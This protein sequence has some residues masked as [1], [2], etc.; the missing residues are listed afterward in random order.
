MRSPHAVGCTV[1]ILTCSVL[2]AS[3]EAHSSTPNAGTVTN[4]SGA[5]TWTGGPFVAPNPTGNAGAVNCTVPRSC[6]DYALTVSTTAGTGD[7]QNLKITVSWTNTAADF[8]AYVLDRAGAVVAS[9]A[10]SSDPETIIMPPT[11]GTYTVRVVPF[12]PL[13]QSYSASAAVVAKPSDTPPTSAAPTPAFTNYGA[14]EALTDSHNA[15]EP[16]IGVSDQ[17]NSS[18]YQSYVSTYRVR[19]DDSVSPATAAWSDVSAK[20]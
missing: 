20:A 4:T 6:D 3:G 18:F 7:T 2:V 14:P 9:S 8:D 15:G 11:S 5:A 16:S 10:S 19:F 1:L 12:A 13:G 17:T